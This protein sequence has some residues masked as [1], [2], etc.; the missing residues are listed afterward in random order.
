MV[1]QR[2]T[3]GSR[4]RLRHLDAERNDLSDREGFQ[5]PAGRRGAA[6]SHVLRF[7]SVSGREQMD[8]KWIPN[9]SRESG[10]HMTQ[11]FLIGTVLTTTPRSLAA[12]GSDAESGTVGFVLFF[13]G[14]REH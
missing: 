14:A 8:P 3:G 6:P 4:I 13:F 5:I 10:Q 11:G 7:W 9:G 2:V 12:L 1:Q